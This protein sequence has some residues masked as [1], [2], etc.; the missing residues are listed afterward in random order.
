MN[1]NSVPARQQ[2]QPKENGERPARG[3]FRLQKHILGPD[4]RPEAV[5]VTYTM[6]CGACGAMGPTAE[7]GEDGMTWAVVHLKHN[8]AHLDYQEHITRPYRAE[9][10]AWL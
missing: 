10:G 8:P 5:P 1:S 2:V 4:R 3:T 7:C 6:S 9:P